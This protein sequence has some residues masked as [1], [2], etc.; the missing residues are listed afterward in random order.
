MSGSLKS[1]SLGLHFGTCGWPL[2]DETH[3][4]R[5]I[6][7]N[8]GGLQETIRLISLTQLDKTLG[9]ILQ[10]SCL[11]FATWWLSLYKHWG[12]KAFPRGSSQTIRQ[13][14][15]R[16]SIDAI[17]VSDSERAKAAAA[18]ARHWRKMDEISALNMG[19][20]LGGFISSPTQSDCSCFLGCFAYFQ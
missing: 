17:D 5:M 14:I 10:R 6:F 19:L 7:R 13:K 11:G 12:W 16:E 18:V 4:N 20:C 2:V 15:G 9:Q 1:L 3:Q 8:Q